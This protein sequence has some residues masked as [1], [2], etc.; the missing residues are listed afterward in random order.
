MQAIMNI[1]DNPKTGLSQLAQ[2]IQEE[3]AHIRTQLKEL[4]ESIKEEL[5]RTAWQENDGTH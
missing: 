2:A 1:M 4:S 5:P 3:A